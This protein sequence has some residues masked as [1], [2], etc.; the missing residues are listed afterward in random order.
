MQSVIDMFRQNNVFTFDL[1]TT[2]IGIINLDHLNLQ[3]V[4]AVPLMEIIPLE[5]SPGKS[6]PPLVLSAQIASRCEN[7]A[8]CELGARRS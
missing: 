7:V 1:Y 2:V 6:C 5:S 8:R 3:W 4:D